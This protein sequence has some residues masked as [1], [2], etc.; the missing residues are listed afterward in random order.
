MGIETPM[1]RSLARTAP[2]VRQFW[3]VLGARATGM[4]VVTSL[5]GAAPVGFVG[6]SASHVTADPPTVLVSLDR[7]TSALAP[8]LESGVFAVNYL[9]ADQRA[10]AEA[11]MARGA[12]MADRFAAGAWRTLETGAPVL[13]HASGAFDCR[14]EAAIEREAAVVVLGRVAGWAVGGDRPPLIFYKGKLLS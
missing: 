9:G 11:F 6:L 10:V 13:E 5:A 1:E 14:V 8:L 7:K 4:T 3:Q 12:E 2:D